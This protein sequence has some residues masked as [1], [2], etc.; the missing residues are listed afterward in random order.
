MV[1]FFNIRGLSIYL[2][3][4]ALDIFMEIFFVVVQLIDK[5]TSQ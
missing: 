2:K 3:S 5:F 1:F 4:V